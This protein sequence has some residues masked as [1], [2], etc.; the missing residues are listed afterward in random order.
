MS[1]NLIASSL[2][3]DN[4]HFE[5]CILEFSIL[6]L[7]YFFNW[8]FDAGRNYFFTSIFHFCFVFPRLS[9][10]Y[11]YWMGK[12]K[13]LFMSAIFIY[14][15]CFGFSLIFAKQFVLIFFLLCAF[16]FDSFSVCLLHSQRP[17]TINKYK[18]IKALP[19]SWQT[20]RI[21]YLYSVNLKTKLSE[22]CNIFN[23]FKCICVFLS[24]TRKKQLKKK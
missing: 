1:R 16:L 20:S 13:Q 10:L 15:W 23:G 5:W 18:K 6:T 2:K 11:F 17:K 9:V 19:L 8:M 24:E 4:N 12:N 21:F 3:Y 7:F 22:S 14:F